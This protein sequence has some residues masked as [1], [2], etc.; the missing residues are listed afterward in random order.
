M[1]RIDTLNISDSKNVTVVL[2][3]YGK[4]D[5]DYSI[6]K[7]R[8]WQDVNNEEQYYKYYN[9]K[10]L[11]ERVNYKDEVS[12]KLEYQYNDYDLLTEVSTYQ[13][14]AVQMRES[15]VYNAENKV[16]QRIIS[17]LVN[18][19]YSY[20]YNSNFARSLDYIAFGNYQFKPLTDVNG[21]NTGR[22]ILGYGTNKIAAEYISYR[23]VGD[24]ATN[25]PS[26]V[27]FGNGEKI[28]DSIKYKYDKCGNITEVTE[29]GH[30]SAKYTYDDLNRIVREDNKPLNKTVLYSYDNNGNITERCEY[31]YTSK[32][33]EELTELNCIHYDYDY[34]GD[35]LESY[36][37]EGFWYNEQGSPTTYRGN[38][39]TWK[40]GKLLESY[41]G[42]N[43][44]YDGLGRRTRKGDIT[45]VYDNDGRLIKQSNGLEFIYDACGVIGVR[46][47][48]RQY[49]YR[50]D[51]R[52]N[53]IAILDSSGTVVV[54]YIYD[55]WGNHAVVDRNDEDID[56]MTN[57]GN[58]NP[59]RYNGY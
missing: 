5:E 28:K 14:N 43:F 35:R 26:T 16:S 55:A 7:L 47:N 59:F 24:R 40:Y 38:P 21:R 22:E 30:T 49:F 15:Y 57:I 53:I 37:G 6:L 9:V 27:W 18:Q 58:M 10:G 1:K 25:M 29:N 19:T 46:Y 3:K 4:M 31:S 13:D 17:G 20:F 51:A 45:Y 52:G 8:E 56:D 11:L 32:I 34:S 41:S 54:K 50:R 2:Y 36:N 42:T 39:M 44:Y 48:N 33:G 23:K 12:K